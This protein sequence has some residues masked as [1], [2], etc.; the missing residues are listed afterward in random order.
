MD[1]EKLDY[2][3]KH[4]IHISTSLDWDEET[5]NFNRTFKDWNSFEQVTYWIKRINE[6]YEKKWIKQK[7]WALL[8]VTKKTLSKY[9]EVIDTY[10]NLWLDWIFLR[11][12]N[13]YGFAAADL[14][15]LGYTMD[16][17]I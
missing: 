3:I 2:I 10:V 16:E 12:L 7:V 8:T 13:P 6:E 5:H 4:N 11:P 15:K 1:D 9:K 17:F 14:K